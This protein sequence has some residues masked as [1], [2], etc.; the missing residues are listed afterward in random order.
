LRAKTLID[1]TWLSRR[2]RERR[3]GA[4]KQ[5]SHAHSGVT[6]FQADHPTA[7]MPAGRMAIFAI[8]RPNPSNYLLS[9]L[10]YG[11]KN[12]NADAVLR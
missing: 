4:H 8:K 5:R 6:N 10:S 2:L 7:P 9:L 11:G 1:M 12:S 3:G